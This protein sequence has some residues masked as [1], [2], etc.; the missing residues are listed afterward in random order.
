[1]GGAFLGTLAVLAAALA[2]GQAA[3]P[4]HPFAPRDLGLLAIYGMGGMAVSQFLFVLGIRRIGVA[5]ASFHINVAPFYVMLIM[6]ALGGD[7]SWTQALGA[8][9]VAG[10]VLLAQ[11]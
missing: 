9:I 3:L 7:W 10:G 6:V 8:A 5:L 4:A 11:R 1:M 2:V